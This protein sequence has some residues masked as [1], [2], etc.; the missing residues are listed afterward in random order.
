MINK[1]GIF[2]YAAGENIAG[3]YRNDIAVVAW[4]NSQGHRE[5]ILD[6]TYNYTGMGV[7][8]GGR[9]GKIYVQIFMGA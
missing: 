6:S 9:Y 4:M 2:W 3:A 1:A 5:N 8:D 7:V